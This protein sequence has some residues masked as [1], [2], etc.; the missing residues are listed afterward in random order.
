MT[1]QDPRAETTGPAADPA[2]L[3]RTIQ[4]FAAAGAR[5]RAKI[6]AGIAV[7]PPLRCGCA[8]CAEAVAGE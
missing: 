5:R 3:Y 2:K 7:D 1:V 4:I 6:A 8:E